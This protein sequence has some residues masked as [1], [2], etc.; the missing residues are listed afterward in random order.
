MYKIINY[1]EEFLDEMIVLWKEECESTNIC[2]Y[3]DSS[4][5]PFISKKYFQNI[6][7]Y[8]IQSSNREIG[9]RN[10]DSDKIWYGEKKNAI[11]NSSI[12]LIFKNTKLSSF[13]IMSESNNKK[14]INLL[15]GQDEGINYFF[16]NH[17]E[18]NITYYCFD[19]K[20]CEILT[21][22]AFKINSK[23]FYYSKILFEHQKNNNDVKEVRED[24]DKNKIN[25]QDI[26]FLPLQLI[27]K[28]K[29]STFGPTFY[30]EENGKMIGFLGPNRIYSI[31]G[32]KIGKLGVFYVKKN[33][34]KKGFGKNL[35]QS[36][37]SYFLK[38]NV[39]Y[40]GFKVVEDNIPAIKL[41][42]S[43]GYKRAVD[44]SKLTR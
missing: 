17:K 6:L 38:N 12:Y 41:Y 40:S 13:V 29:L 2:I 30:V 26:N 44:I 34:R 9:L 28:N 5:Y 42:E 37:M 25:F 19:K 24:F 43:M 14:K 32:L 21:N 27:V 23:L 20:K 18:T 4:I 8:E 1:S 11:F 10:Y 7:K 31:E 35:I 3:P 22:N 33:A 39:D 36:T 15:V 16:E